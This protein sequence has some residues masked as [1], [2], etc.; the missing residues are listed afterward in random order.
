[1]LPVCI[2]LC[3]LAAGFLLI[4]YCTY[5]LA[6]RS[7]PE[8]RDSHFDL[9]ASRQYQPYREESLARIRR[10]LA[11]EYEPVSVTSFDGLK[12][13]GRYY[14]RA[15]GA[16]TAL[17]VHGWRSTG[18]RDFCG[19]AFFL[20]ELGFNVLLIDQ[21]GQGHSGGRAMTFGV[22]ERHDCLTWIR[23]LN[24]RF[25]DKPDIFLYGVSMGAAAV[26]MAAG[27]ELPDNV[28]AIAADSPYSA[29]A[30]IIRKVCRDRGIPPAAAWPFLYTGARL[31]AQF[32]PNE[33][34]AA[35]SAAKAS[36]PILI[37]HGT[38][39]RFVPCAM[40]EEIAAASPLVK[41]EVFDGAGHCLAFLTDRPR[42]EA[43]IRDLIGRARL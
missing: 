37:I 41:R 17:C 8:K 9:P 24:R 3:L 39:D 1:M 35:D 16:P 5:T 19:G 10:L 14:H 31:F 38:D 29:P 42:Y 13:T 26:L 6:F 11:E 2:V 22:K 28:R 33:I 30:E 15:D 40:S 7:P 21:R 4:S 32:D 36:V 34:T 12:L 20:M 27:L 25:P 18:V 23:Y 43:L